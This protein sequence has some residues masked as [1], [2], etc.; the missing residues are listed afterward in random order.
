[1]LTPKMPKPCSAYKEATV[2]TSKVYT[3]Y[4]TKVDA[5]FDQLLLAKIVKLRP[6]HNIPKA[7]DLKGKMYCKYHNS[8]NHKTN[9]Y[10]IFCDANQSWIDNGKLKFPEKQMIVDVDHFPSMTVSMVDVHLPKDEG[11]GKAEFIPMQFI[12]KQNSRS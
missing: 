6:G 8:N 7:K 4:I 11:K 9:N 3:F 12:S 5:N 10:V 2:K 1:M